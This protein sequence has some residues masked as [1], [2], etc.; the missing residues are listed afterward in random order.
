MP[1]PLQ[2]RS[3]DA[4]EVT[5]NPNLCAHAGL[6]L[7]GLPEVFN[8]QARPWIQPEHAPADDLA[9]VVRRCPSGALTYHRLDGGEDE[10]PDD[11]VTM[12]PVRNGPIYAR[13]DLEILDG[14]GNVLRRTT[15]AALCRCGSS[16]NKPYCDGTHVKTGF[17]TS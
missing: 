5:F 14:E 9:E 4:I 3:T 12:R 11:R 7:R 6:C 1:K 17:R 13:G 10:Q 2:V 16:E 15:R 8:L